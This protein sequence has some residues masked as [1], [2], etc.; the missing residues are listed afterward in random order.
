MEG[1]NME[2]IYEP[3]PYDRSL[4]LVMAGFVAVIVA[5]ALALTLAR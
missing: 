2:P 3:I 4:P 5:V 1:V